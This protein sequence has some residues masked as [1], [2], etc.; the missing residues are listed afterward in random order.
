MPM[1]IP[2]PDNG[3]KPEEGLQAV[4]GRPAIVASRK[5][6]ASAEW[7][8]R[9]D[10]LSNLTKLY[11]A[12]ADQELLDALS[13]I[14]GP[15]TRGGTQEKGVKAQGARDKRRTNKEAADTDTGEA[16]VLFPLLQ[17]LI[18]EEDCDHL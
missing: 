8:K 1:S 17:H 3:N 11:V 14:R 4:T 16:T 10:H 13:I 15:S 2:A 7:R 12:G 18:I 5:S 6:M 9:F